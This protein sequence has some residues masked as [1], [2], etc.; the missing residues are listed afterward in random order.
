MFFDSE[1]LGSIPS[2][3]FGARFFA[4]VIR[5]FHLCFGHTSGA[6]PRLQMKIFM[7]TYFVM[8]LLCMSH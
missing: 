2:V 3:T 1:Q 8:L 7:L 6:F 4:V 5:F